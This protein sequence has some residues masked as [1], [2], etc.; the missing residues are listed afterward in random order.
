[1]AERRQQQGHGHHHA[2]RQ[3]S[4]QRFSTHLSMTGPPASITSGENAKTRQPAK[5]R[6]FFDAKARRERKRERDGKGPAALPTPTSLRARLIPMSLPP[7]LSASPCFRGDPFGPVRDFR[8]FALSLS[9]RMG[10]G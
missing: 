4:L 1:R 9:L 5:A 2:A 3:D 8:A 7:L 6:R 10:W